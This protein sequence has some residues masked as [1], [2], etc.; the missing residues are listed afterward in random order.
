MCRKLLVLI[1]VFGFVGSV[2]AALVHEWELD[3]T[4]NDTSGSGNH[5][6]LTGTATYVSPVDDWCSATGKAMSF[7]GSTVITDLTTSNIPIASTGVYSIRSPSFSMNVFFKDTGAQPGWQGIGGFGQYAAHQNRML[8]TRYSST[9]YFNGYLDDISVG[10]GYGQVNWHMV[11]VSFDQSTAN[12][13]YQTSKMYIDGSLYHSQAGRTL[14]N[15]VDDVYLGDHAWASV[16]G[17]SGLLDGFQIYNH[18]LNQT[19]VDALYTRIPEPATIALLGL[20]GL[21]LLRRKR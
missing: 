1:M 2:Q 17:W 5:G 20:G 7:N 6:T 16:V 8:A 21:A 18:V 4:L 11:T 14:S 19:E 12:P 13:V 10:F 15:T 3:N 9:V